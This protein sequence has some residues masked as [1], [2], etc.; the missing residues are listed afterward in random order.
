MSSLFGALGYMFGFGVT[1]QE[2]EESQTE[3][4][5]KNV[6]LRKNRRKVCNNF[7]C[8]S[9]ALRKCKANICLTCTSVQ[10]NCCNIH[11][12]PLYFYKPK[13]QAAPPLVEYNEPFCTSCGVNKPL[14][15]CCAD[16][17]IDCDSPELGCC[18]AHDARRP[19]FERQQVVFQRSHKKKQRQKRRKYERGMQKAVLTLE[20]N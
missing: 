11:D 10:P 1:Q 4:P 18:R 17:C 16:F 19:K 14:S 8:S 6:E 2:Q 12:D 9:P 15:K 13:C 3:K 20:S 7:N 5:K